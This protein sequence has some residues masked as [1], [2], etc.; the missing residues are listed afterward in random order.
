M[1]TQWFPWRMK[2]KE[3]SDY[4]TGYDMI[5]KDSDQ[6][7]RPGSDQECY[8]GFQPQLPRGFRA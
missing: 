8:S 5:T 7:Q 3:A 1:M 6:S 4:D 2:D